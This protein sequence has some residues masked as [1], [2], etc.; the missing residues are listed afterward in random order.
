MPAAPYDKLIKRYAEYAPVYDRRWARYSSATLARSLEAVRRLVLPDDTAHTGGTPVPLTL[1]PPQL[2]DVACGT[3]IFAAMIRDELPRITIV[4]VDL[5][6]DMLTKFR[7]RFAGDDRVSAHAG[8]AEQ[9]PFANDRFEILT[10][11]NA[12]HL[13]ADAPAA[14]AEFRR[15]LKPG[16]HVV[17][18]DWCRDYLSIKALHAYLRGFGKHPRRVRRLREL[19]ELVSGAG[20]IIREQQR[21]KATAFW[22]MMRVVARKE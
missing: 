8:S 7:D 15:V 14:L 12:F 3:G 9:I 1:T 21:F 4:G 2:L 10:C 11:N 6:A 22:G 19:V 17:I 18:V 20:F 16:G 5:S 13:I